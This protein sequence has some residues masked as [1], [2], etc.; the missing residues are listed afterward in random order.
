MSKTVLPPL[1]NKSM[2]CCFI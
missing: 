1:L 2:R